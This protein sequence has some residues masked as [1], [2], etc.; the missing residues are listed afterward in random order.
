MAAQRSITSSYR[1][2]YDSPFDLQ[3]FF[4]DRAL[5][6]ITDGIEEAIEKI[7]AV[8]KEDIAT[9]ARNIKHEASYF[10]GGIESFNT[11]DEQDE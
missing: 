8:T 7:L 9:L 5:F 6:G 2:L 11:E 3:A 4:G 1:Q 10:I